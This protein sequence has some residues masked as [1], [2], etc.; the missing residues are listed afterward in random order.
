MSEKPILERRVFAPGD[1]I[2]REGDQGD[3]AYI[4]QKGEVEIV[5]K[6]NETDKILATIG[7]GG[8]FGEMA[9]IDNQPRMAAARA[10]AVTTTL[11][12]VSRRMFEHKLS[13]TDP[14]IR[15]LL[16]IIAA[17]LRR[18]TGGLRPPPEGM[19]AH[20]APPVEAEQAPETPTPASKQ[21]DN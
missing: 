9:L 16:K 14:F 13:K 20:P 8:I 3:A 11:I 21:A 4:V 6:V 5:R 1:R 2:F 19:A 18:T 10:G 17:N 7:E 15:G 12:L